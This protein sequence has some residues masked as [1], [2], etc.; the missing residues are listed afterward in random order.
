MDSNELLVRS[1]QRYIVETFF[2]LHDI[3]KSSKESLFEVISLHGARGPLK[4][5]KT[6]KVD[7][8]QTGLC[9]EGFC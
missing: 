4:I 1:L 5:K 2:A 3:Q 9:F 6:Q 8:M 7:P